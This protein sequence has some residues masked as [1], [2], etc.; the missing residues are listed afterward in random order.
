VANV[1]N[2]RLFYKILVFITRYLAP[3]TYF[4]HP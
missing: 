3:R 1:T 4:K 2:H